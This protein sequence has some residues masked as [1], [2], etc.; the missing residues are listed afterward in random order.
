[1]NQG[2]KIGLLPLYIKLYDVRGTNR[3]P[4]EQCLAAVRAMLESGG[5]EV[6]AAPV[7]RIREEFDQAADL[8]EQADVDA[9]VTFHLAYSPSLEAIDALCRLNRPV[10]V[11]DTTLTYD[12]SVR[13]ERRDVTF[14]HGIHGVMD[15]CNLMRRR[16]L[17]YVVEAGHYLH[18]D[19]ISRVLSRC[20]A[21][22]AA[23]AF[24]RGRIGRM[25]GAFDGMGDFVRT[26]EQMRGDFGAE[27]VHFS[28]PEDYAAYPVT[29]EEIDAELKWDREHYRIEV[30]NL[31]NYRAETRM[32]LVLRKWCEANGLTACTVNFLGMEQQKMP[33]LEI[34]KAISRGLGYAGEGDVLTANLVAALMHVYRDVT[35]TE[36]F[37]PCWKNGLILLS[38]MGE[39]NLSL[40]RP[41]PVVV[42]KAFTY[43]PAGDTVAAYGSYRAGSA[44]LINL[45]PMEDG[46]Y[47]LILTP[48]EMLDIAR[49][50]GT[51]RYE[52]E[53]WLRTPL[54]LETF[55]QKFSELG[56]THHSALVYDVEAAELACFGK[57][58]GFD[59][60]VLQ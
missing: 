29:E 8:F 59:V 9:V 46:K 58:M 16:G 18:S 4:M 22:A 56:G 3:E 47:S 43:T 5:A 21:A 34:S 11:C 31:E 10:I 32:G 23:R 37:C 55:L 20:R 1:M 60:H 53:G 27:V 38:H 2:M 24:R 48:V 26:D 54:P 25:G 50:H 36:T 35:F 40:S 51:Y 57:L 28:F 41:Q 17:P 39:M 19:V 15:L 12:M 6:V 30:Q 14:N 52:V 33:F 42:D 7:C 44:V 45:A 13:M 49:D